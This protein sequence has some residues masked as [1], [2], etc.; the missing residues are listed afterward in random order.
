MFSCRA[1]SLQPHLE[2]WQVAV[3]AARPCMQAVQP[4]HGSREGGHGGRR[5]TASGVDVGRRSIRCRRFLRPHLMS[6]DIAVA[7]HRMRIDAV[8]VCWIVSGLD[9]EEARSTSRIAP[10]RRLALAG[11]DL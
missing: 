9:V 10:P 6:V 11:M 2:S 7:A 4:H 8:G 1:S 3:V 5:G